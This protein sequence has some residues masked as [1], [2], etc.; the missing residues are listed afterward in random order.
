MRIL[1]LCSAF[2]GLSQR[3]FVELTDEGH[4]VFVE[5]LTDEGHLLAAIGQARPD[6]IIAPFLT[7]AIPEH[8]WRKHRC[9]I[10]HPGIM[11]DRG[12]ASL[13]WAISEGWS[14]WGVTL[15][16]ADAEM[17]AG[18]IWAT[19][20]FPMRRI[21]KSR[22][23]GQDVTDAAV[24]CLAEL[25]DK[26]KREVGSGLPLD[27]GRPDVRGR[28][29]PSM[30]RADRELD[31]TSMPA[32]TLVARIL[33]ADG[34]PGAAMELAGVPV[35]VFNVWPAEPE[36]AAGRGAPGAIFARAGDAV[37]VGALDGALWL[38]HLRRTD[39]HR[40]AGIKLPAV[41][42]LAEAMPAG[43]RELPREAAPLELGRAW[44]ERAG[45]IGLVHFPFLNGAFSTA[46]S[47]ELRAVI[48][49][50]GADP[51][52][53]AIVLTGG[54]DA[55]SNGIDLNTIEAA[56][57]PAA[58][59]WAS[60]NAI[61]DVAEAIFA[62]QDKL[63][64]SALGANAGAGGA[65]LAL[66]A[67]RV[68]MRDGVV[69]NPHYRTIG[70]LGSEFW[71]L[72][73][74]ARVGAAM[75][76]ELTEACLPVGAA[77]ALEIGLVDEIVA[78][79]REDFLNETLRRVGGMIAQHRLPE[80]LERKRERLQA[81]TQGRSLAKVRAAEL[82]EMRRNFFADDLGFAARRKA[83]VRKE[84]PCRTPDHLLRHNDGLAP[85]ELKRAS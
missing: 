65:M 20:N 61:D 9:F 26:L 3:F 34:M 85:V 74:P 1:L 70:L 10:L 29:R 51:T 38:G 27:Y 35:R 81:L 40:F 30:R 57:D 49:A 11:G 78:T 36:L 64:V 4:E 41:Q 59:G 14:E 32:T 5:I 53:D 2:N 63:V 71:T 76:R 23:Y 55:W 37:C 44:L 28:E 6:A 72:T 52:L 67:D 18:D 39:E 13:D 45:R 77:R 80:V 33:A 7:R 66:A 43:V 84:R 73:L 82:T 75:A 68:V 25:M 42:A 47:N 21:R 8:V 31:W 56:A 22:V 15:L 17:D 54:P 79:G 19:R 50:A 62:I 12:P 83:F 58:E 60:I 69:L 46:A 48:E 24:G 16:Q